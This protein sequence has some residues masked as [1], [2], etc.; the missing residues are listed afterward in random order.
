MPDIHPSSIQLE[1]AMKSTLG[2]WFIPVMMLTVGLIVSGYRLASR[3]AALNVTEDV[4]MPRPI[5]TTR[6]SNAMTHGNGGII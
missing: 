3:Q 5:N 6:Q 2:F 4:P 1:P